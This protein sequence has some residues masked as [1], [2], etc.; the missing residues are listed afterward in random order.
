MGGWHVHS[1]HAGYE[2]NPLL[3]S[4]LISLDPNQAPHNVGPDQ[5]PNNLI[6]KVY[7]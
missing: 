2:F 7:L 4:F 1:L 6:F 5:D 3:I